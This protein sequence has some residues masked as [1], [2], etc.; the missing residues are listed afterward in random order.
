L[1]SATA[2]RRVSQVV[3][4]TVTA[5]QRV[6]DATTTLTAALEREDDAVILALDDA[7]GGAAQ[8]TL[9]RELV[10]AA[11]A[12]I[13]DSTL[14]ADVTMYETAVDELVKGEHGPLALTNYREVVNPLL[15]RT[16]ATIERIRDDHFASS[17]RVAEWAGIQSTRSMQIVAT[18][19]GVALL[20]LLLVVIHFARAVVAPI[21]EMT[22]VVQAI[23]MGDFSQRVKS[24][25]DDEI[26]RLG[27]GLS[28]MA[29]ELEEFRRTN[30]REVIHAKETLEA[31]LGAF[32]DAVLV[33][34]DERTVTAA[35][36]RAQAALPLPEPTR[37][38]V[39]KVL[40]TGIVPPLTVDFNKTIELTIDGQPRRLLPRI[41]PIADG[42]GAVLVLSDVTEL[43]RLDERRIELVAVAS[44][45]LR[46]P[47]TTMR[48]TLSMLN[49][50]SK[51][52]NPRDRELI[53]TAILGVEQLAALVDEFLDLTR[54]E[55]GQLRLN[56]T[57]VVSHELVENAIKS[58]TPGAEQA[59][60]TLEVVEDPSTPAMV[61]GDPAR[62]AMVLSNLLTNAIKY[63]PAGGRVQVRTSG[64]PSELTLEVSDTGPGI[65]A[66]FRE[67][68]FE[69]FFRVEHVQ[70]SAPPSAGVGIGLYISRQVIELH[71]GTIRCDAGPLGGARFTV[72]F[73]KN[74]GHALAN[75]PASS[76]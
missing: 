40:T 12:R 66:E 54:I 60:V 27:T 57:R 63:T 49:E 34:D 19:S 25:R 5:N 21:V 43:A 9:E 59:K 67:R 23:R 46:T 61:D 1:W 6:T 2:F 20:M 32:P 8:L 76:G 75:D 26:G 17:Q 70:K 39:E 72:T 28:R 36:P 45:E 51:Q 18:I 10:A 71:G 16:E 4:D 44:H 55:A 11:L 24:Q 64:T 38:A 47:L 14:R 48:M 52:Y 69:R 31:T 65:P 22:R 30:I 3:S 13:D 56:W 35:N 50:H 73:G 74:P 41:V 58:A 29:D 33:I 62:I 7:A 53:S 37:A 42:R 15:R 68:V